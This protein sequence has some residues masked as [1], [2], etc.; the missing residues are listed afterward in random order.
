MR[1]KTLLTTLLVLTVALAGCTQLPG[2]NNSNTQ[3]QNQGVTATPNDGLSIQWQPVNNQFYTGEGAQATF[4]A[5]I[6]NTG[7]GDASG[8]CIRVFGA[9]WA[10][11]SVNCEDVSPSSLDPAQPDANIEGG[12]NVY[13]FRRDISGLSLGSG[14][15][16]RYDV[17][18]SVAYDYTSET[19]STLELLSET[20]WQEQNPS[21]E[22]MRNEVSAGPV[23][24]RFTSNT[25]ARFTQSPDNSPNA[26]DNAKVT[27]PISMSVAVSNVGSGD[28]NLNPPQLQKLSV[29]VE[30]TDGL[31]KVK[32]WDAPTIYNGQREF[33][34]DYK[35]SG[36]VPSPSRDVTMIANASYKYVERT[37]TSVQLIGGG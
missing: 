15:S 8:F 29:W 33:T 2:G 20:A 1:Q 18:L 30:G 6:Q 36:P 3:D 4:E 24:L 12:R 22:T 28:I 16:D 27:D 19:R 17:G 13:T 26:G 25:P 32:S 10:S 37:S 14:E 35:P 11:S 7:T 9:S 34:F 31:K 5:T 23:H 21:P